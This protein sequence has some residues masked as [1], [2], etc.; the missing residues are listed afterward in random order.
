MARPGRPQAAKRRAIVLHRQRKAGRQALP[1]GAVGQPEGLRRD[2]PGAPPGPL[3]GATGSAHHATASSGAEASAAASPASG[4]PPPGPSPIGGAAQRPGGAAAG[5]PDGAPRGAA[6]RHAEAAPKTSR[7]WL[8]AL[9]AGIVGGAIAALALSYWALSREGGQVAALRAQVQGMEQA[10]AGAEGRSGDVAQLIH[11][12]RCAREQLGRRGRTTV[13]G[14]I[15]GIKAANA[16]LQKRLDA[17][18]P[19]GRAA[20]AG[21][22]NPGRS[23]GAHGCRCWRLGGRGRT[24][25]LA[26][27]ETKLGDLSATVARLEQATAG[28][29]PELGGLTSRVGALEARLGQAEER[30]RRSRAWPAASAR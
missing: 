21:S 29:R 30:A 5:S 4:R 6:P 8:G 9:A 2:A 17:F 19:G 24:R 10:L 22:G 15:E 25:P 12:G 7:S 13:K 20:G 16:D 11:A 26:E 3:P 18:E 27:L 28:D 23:A 14:Q 1:G